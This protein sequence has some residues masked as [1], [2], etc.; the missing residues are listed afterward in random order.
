MRVVISGASGLIGTALTKSLRADDHE[1]IALVRRSPQGPF[2]SEWDPAGGVIDQDVVQSADAVVNFAGASI[3]AKRLTN[4]HK[5]LVKQSRVDSTDL[6]ARAYAPRTDGVLLSGSAMGFYG[7]RGTEELSE[8]SA[9]GDTFLSDIVLAW[10]AAAEPAV[11]AG[12]RTVF[13]RSGLVLAPHGGFAARLL[14][15]VKRG[16]LGG[17]GSANP[18]HAWITLHDEV[19]ALRYLID[20]DHAGPANIIAPSPVR[21]QDLMDALSAAVGKKAGLV[22]PAW[23]LEI[24]IGPAIDDLLSSQKATPGVLTRL[25]FTWDHATIDEAATWVM[26]EAGLAPPSM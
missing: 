9:P 22:V 24:A 1:V 7:A 11:E 12:V 14:P 3:G 21:D 6:I 20:S 4:S 23:M 26:T 15:L 19:R 16:I 10:E 2:E 13:I 17:L 8:R 18:W 5:R 25:G